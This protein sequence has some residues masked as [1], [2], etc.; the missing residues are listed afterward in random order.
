MQ[1]EYPYVLT[2][3]DDA[4][5]QLQ[6]DHLHLWRL[7]VPTVTCKCGCTGKTLEVLGRRLS[8]NSRL[9]SGN[10]TYRIT[11]LIETKL[12]HID[13]NHSGRKATQ[14]IPNGPYSHDWSLCPWPLKRGSGNS[15]C[16][17]YS[18]VHLLFGLVLSHQ[19]GGPRVCLKHCIRASHKACSGSSLGWFRLTECSI[20]TTVLAGTERSASS[21]PPLL[22]RDCAF[23]GSQVPPLTYQKTVLWANSLSRLHE[24]FFLFAVWWWYLLSLTLRMM[25]VGRLWSG[26]LSTSMWTWWSCCCPKA[27]TSISG[28][29]WVFHSG[30]ETLRTQPLRRLEGLGHWAASSVCQAFGLRNVVLAHDG[31]FGPL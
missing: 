14:E 12:T 6:R 10:R 31:Y 11:F 16:A 24:G 9:L 29:M 17:W 19:K 5:S 13:L 22:S 26:P 20:Q 3:S 4:S 28:T 27:L 15:L 30:L 1:H 18:S 7:C 23:G 21:L 8:R 2:V 25:V